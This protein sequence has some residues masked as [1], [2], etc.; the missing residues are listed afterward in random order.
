MNNLVNDR[1][2]PKVKYI[3]G[4]DLLSQFRQ[5]S[6]LWAAKKA[7]KFPHSILYTQ[8]KSQVYETTSTG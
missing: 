7:L 3:E 2:N 1:S 8:K 5:T 4:D 6:V